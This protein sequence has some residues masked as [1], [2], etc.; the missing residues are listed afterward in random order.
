MGEEPGGGGAVENRAAHPHTPPG[1][2]ETYKM[3]ASPH[4]NKPMSGAGSPSKQRRIQARGPGARPL[5][6]DQTEARG[7]ENIFL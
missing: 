7:D 5:F 3:S 6:L 1:D 2:N 4:S